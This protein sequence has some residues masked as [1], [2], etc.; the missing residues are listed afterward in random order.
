M[1]VLTQVQHVV[2]PGHRQ[3]TLS[4]PSSQDQ[5]TTKDNSKQVTRKTSLGIPR[6]RGPLKQANLLD[7]P[8][9]A[10]LPPPSKFTKET[11]DDVGKSNLFVPTGTI[12][13]DDNGES[14]EPTPRTAL[15]KVEEIDRS[16]HE[17][18]QLDSSSSE[19][20]QDKE[21]PKSLTNENPESAS[22]GNLSSNS[23]QNSVGVSQDSVDGMKKNAPIPPPRK[24]TGH[25]RSSSLDLQKLFNNKGK[26]CFDKLL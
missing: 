13:P 10:I 25:S 17:D 4:D 23:S 26:L 21:R 24:K 14:E 7:T 5:S 20:E 2:N 9:W 1:F 16:S 18:I 6:I 22:S 15:L 19:T 12:I 8:H 3:R 11:P